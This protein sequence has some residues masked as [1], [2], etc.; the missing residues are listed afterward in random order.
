MLDLF[1]RNIIRG[2]IF[3]SALA[4]LGLIAPAQEAEANSRYG[5]KPP[6]ILSPD[7]TEPWQLQITPNRKAR[8]VVRSQNSK[9]YR[10]VQS[11]AHK[12]TKKRKAKKRTN[13]RIQQAALRQP[14][15]H[16]NRH[17]PLNPKFL[18]QIVEYNTH[19]KPGTIIVDTTNKFLYLVMAN[20]EARRY[21]VG[22]GREG[23]G[24]TGT[25]KVSRKAEWPSWRPPAEMIAREAAKGRHLPRFMPGGPENPMGARGI[26]LGSTLYRIHGT[27]APWTIGQAVSSGCF[28]MRNEDVIDLYPRV[29]LGAKVV[30]I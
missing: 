9:S 5:A 13:S 28:R 18:P 25:E 4:V 21:G 22:V 30:V 15:I 17:K 12:V 29:G 3:L 6:V 24:W 7:L 14:D 26:Y 10:P 27:N 1:N 8:L 20:G 2:A 19:H 23:F 11:Q 16:R